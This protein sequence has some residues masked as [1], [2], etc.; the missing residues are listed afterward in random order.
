MIANITTIIYILSVSNESINNG[1]LQKGTAISRIDDDEGFQ[2]YKYSNF[3]TSPYDSNSDE[4]DNYEIT[5]LKE[6]NIYLI[7]GKFTPTQDNSINVT[8]TTN[9]HI[10]LDKEDIPIMKPTVNLLG[11]TT[12]YAQLS[13]TGYTLPIQVKPYLSKDQYIPFMVNLTHPPNGRFKNA[14]TMAKKNSTIHTTGVFFLAESQLYC[15]ILEFQFVSGKIDT[16]NTISVPWKSKAD[17]YTESPKSSLEKRIALVRQNLTTQESLSTSSSTQNP[18]NKHKT[19]TTKILDISKSL[20]SQD[21]HIEI[22]DSDQEKAENEEE[23]IDNNEDNIGN[24]SDDFK[25]DKGKKGTLTKVL[26]V[27]GR[28]KRKKLVNK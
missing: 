15:E 12:G 2:I 18:K 8:I 14:L 16:D 11:K 17:S 28:G 9:V 21:Q 7:S 22:N 4:N 3:L 23:T 1:T 10:P 24:E 13:E 26:P 5:P 27:R 20:L 6:E 25:N 19:S